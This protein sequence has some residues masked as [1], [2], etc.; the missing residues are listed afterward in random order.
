MVPEDGGLQ[1][2]VA[3]SSRQHHCHHACECA[4]NRKIRILIVTE[5]ATTDTYTQSRAFTAEIQ[6]E[7]VAIHTIQQ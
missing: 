5:Q 1:L 2:H 7:H 6:H 4:E 3:M